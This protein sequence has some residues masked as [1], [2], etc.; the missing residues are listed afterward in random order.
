LCYKNYL[1]VAR[2]VLSSFELCHAGINFPSTLSPS[3]FALTAPTLPFYAYDAHLAIDLNGINE[4]HFDK[5]E[6]EGI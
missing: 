4:P 2:F 6:D 3:S 1:C 5:D